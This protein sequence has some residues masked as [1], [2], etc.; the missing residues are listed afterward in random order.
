MVRFNCLLSVLQKGTYVFMDH[1]E[2][3]FAPSTILWRCHKGY[4]INRIRFTMVIVMLWDVFRFKYIIIGECQLEKVNIQELFVNCFPLLTYL[5]LRSYA[6]KYIDTAPIDI[7][8]LQKIQLSMCC[9][10]GTLLLCIFVYFI[11][12]I[13]LSIRTL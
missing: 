2:S 3:M 13:L 6:E 4:S 11:A 7:F 5:R 9:Y 12:N 10:I 1:R 8:Y